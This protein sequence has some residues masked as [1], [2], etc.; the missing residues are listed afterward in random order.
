MGLL[1]WLKRSTKTTTAGFSVALDVTQTLSETD[2]G[3]ADSRSHQQAAAFKP[4]KFTS[5]FSS[6]ENT[7]LDDG[8]SL[9]V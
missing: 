8:C 2:P 5:V 7:S 9:A 1:V 3:S 4:E 6:G